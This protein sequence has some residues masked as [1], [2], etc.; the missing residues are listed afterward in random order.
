MNSTIQNVVTQSTLMT[1]YNLAKNARVF[2]PRRLDRALGI[3]QRNDTRLLEDGR[4]DTNVTDWQL[5]TVKQCTCEDYKRHGAQW[6]CKH[7]IAKMLVV[8]AQRL[9]NTK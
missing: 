9:E 8:K 4:L 7:R 1:A 6:F 2:E 3:V 5:A